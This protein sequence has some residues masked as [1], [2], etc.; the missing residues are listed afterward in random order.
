MGKR[1]GVLGAGIALVA[2]AV[3]LV[4]PAWGSSGDKDEQTTF[5]LLA[6]IT[7]LQFQGTSLGDQI[8]FTN[9]LLR[10][11]TEVG[12]EG[13]VCTVTSAE[14]QQAQC[15]ATFSLRGGQITAQALVHLG[16]LTPYL[17]AIT[18]GSGKYEGAEGEIRVRPVSQDSGIHVFH[19]QD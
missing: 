13:A 12:H 9:K 14:R 6:V 17:V 10:G 16:T 5:R 3:G 19:L 18:G 1:L 8:V 4:G 15:V 2:L 11:D 7:E